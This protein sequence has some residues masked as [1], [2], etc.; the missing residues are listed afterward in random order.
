ASLRM[1][2][3]EDLILSEAKNPKI[4]WTTEALRVIGQDACIG[5]AFVC[6][7]M[8]MQKQDIK[9]VFFVWT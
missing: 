5:F 8:L 3:P 2:V 7:I 1:T 4:P 6:Y 9:Q